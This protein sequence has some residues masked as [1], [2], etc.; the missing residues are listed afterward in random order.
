MKKIL[1]FI[2]KTMAQ[3]VLA[4]YRPEVIGITGSV[5]KTSTKEAVYAVL[6]GK[7]NI[8][9][10]LKNYNNEL[11]L[12]L[13]ILGADSPGKSIWGW[14]E[15]LGH[16]LKLLIIKDKD[17]PSVL[18]L[19]MGIDRPGDMKYLT[20]IV[21]PKIGLVTGVGSSHLEFFAKPENIQKEKRVLVASL[22]KD[23]L[24]VLNYDNELTRE[25]SGVVIC[26]VL[27]YGLAEGADIMAQE[28]NF[29]FRSLK[30]TAD[31]LGV[32]FKLNYRGAIVPVFLPHVIG[33]PPIYAALAASAV[34]LHYSI[35]LVEIAQ[36]LSDFRLPAGRLNLISGRKNTKIID[37]TYNSSPDSCLAALAILAEVK[38]PQGQKIAVLGD[39]LELGSASDDGHR[40][41]GQKAAESVDLLVAVGAN[42]KII[43]AEAEKHGLKDVIYKDNSLEA[44]QS[45]LDIISEGDLI[46]V[47]G[48]QGARM[49]KVVKV[50]MAEP[51][52][53]QELLVRQDNKWQ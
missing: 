53:A 48:S 50:L 25:M 33:Y 23:S 29:N 42:G 12:P 1:Q 28:I 13:T 22:K 2:L 34:A 20:S 6:K 36:A 11:G 4:R 32:S 39:M 37:D 7:F 40:Q 26:Q 31:L 51:E 44:A 43:G 9:R 49:E 27:T 3:L 19:E 52:K 15:V 5:G 41:V 16:F 45:I 10:S 24:A 46:L 17:Y 14:L 8:R 18:I 35:N 38:V 47:K 30:S 21:K